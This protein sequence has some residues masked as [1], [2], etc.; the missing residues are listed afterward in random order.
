MFLS[1]GF[2]EPR[3]SLGPKNQEPNTRANLSPR[4]S[5]ATFGSMILPKKLSVEGLGSFVVEG[6]VESV[7]FGNIPVHSEVVIAELLR[8]RNHSSR[9]RNRCQW[10]ILQCDVFAAHTWD[11]GNLHLG[12]LC[13]SHATFFSF[14]CK[15]D[16][17]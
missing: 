15:L 3:W 2:G 7:L 1:K 9:V 11:R 12:D 5:S 16:R 8:S 4:V 17:D 6:H 13:D 10:Q 14:D